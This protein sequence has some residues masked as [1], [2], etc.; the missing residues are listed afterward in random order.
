M[1][2][3]PVKKGP[4]HD[5]SLDF[6]ATSRSEVAA[7]SRDFLH[8]NEACGDF[9]GKGLNCGDLAG[10]GVAT[11]SPDRGLPRLRRKGACDDFV[12]KELAGLSQGKGLA[13]TSLER[14]LQ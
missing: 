11:T 9:A 7:T 13:T 5:Q 12:G 3:T 10:K 4:C 14:C 2:C 1:H 8:A 6:A